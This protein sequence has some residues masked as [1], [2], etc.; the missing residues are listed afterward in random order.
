MHVQL[1]SVKTPGGTPLADFARTF[2]TIYRA[3][4][5]VALLFLGMLVYYFIYLLRTD[6]V[7]PDKKRLW[8][9]VLFL[10][11][12]LAMPVFWYYYM[13]PRSSGLAQQ[14]HEAGGPGQPSR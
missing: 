4:F 1:K 3:N 7:P 13:W 6:R 12:F 11:N 2:D 9:V 8:G 14:A 10:G 5:V